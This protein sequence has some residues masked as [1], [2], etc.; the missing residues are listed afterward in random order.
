[1]AARLRHLLGIKTNIGSTSNHLL[2]GPGPNFQP[3]AR[4][5]NFL[6]YS[7][8]E[9]GR[10]VLKGV[11][12]HGGRWSHVNHLFFYSSISSWSIWSRLIK[13]RLGPK[14]LQCSRMICDD[15]L[16]LTGGLCLWDVFMRLAYKRNSSFGWEDKIKCIWNKWNCMSVSQVVWQHWR[17]TIQKK[18][19]DP[20]GAFD[21]S[22]RDLGWYH[23]LFF[24]LFFVFL[25]RRNH[26]FTFA[27][28]KSFIFWP[29]FKFHSNEYF[30]SA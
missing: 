12:N 14:S 9:W 20:P 26:I 13:V 23:I 1:M 30:V 6:F 25:V 29:S 22:T 27:F 3:K 2:I 15:I 19:N 8:T 18:I 16:D 17:R 28:S 21:R 7:W 10:Q 4:G 11:I 5:L 24:Y